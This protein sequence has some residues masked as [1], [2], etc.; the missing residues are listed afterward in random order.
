MS[1][2]IYTGLMNMRMMIQCKDA[3]RKGSRLSNYHFVPP[4]SFHLP[5]GIRNRLVDRPK[6][7]ASSGTCSSDEAWFNKDVARDTA[8][9]NRLRFIVAPMVRFT[10]LSSALSSV[11]EASSKGLRVTLSAER[12]CEVLEGRVSRVEVCVRTGCPDPP[13]GALESATGAS[14]FLIIRVALSSTTADIGLLTPATELE[15]DAS[16]ADVCPLLLLPLEDKD[17]ATDCV[18]GA[19]DTASLVRSEEARLSVVSEPER[20]LA[21]LFLYEESV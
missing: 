11:S 13:L 18:D 19:F 14:V 6:A 1:W 2:N 21:Q 20:L 4:R 12:F 9:P 15:S 5:P 3:Q 17:G 16:N 7:A 8:G 10:L